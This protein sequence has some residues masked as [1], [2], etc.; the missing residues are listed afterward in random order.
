MLPTGEYRVTE[1]FKAGKMAAE[2]GLMIYWAAEQDQE[3]NS[4]AVI[5]DSLAG[6]RVR[7]QCDGH[8][9]H[10]VVFNG[11]SDQEYTALYRA[12]HLDDECT[13][14]EPS[15]GCDRISGFGAAGRVN[16]CEQ[17]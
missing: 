5:A 6:I 3:G 10:W 17:N 13:E 16:E 2:K 9:K 7:Y 8:F 4:A 1:E 11:T 15:E 12:I 14:R